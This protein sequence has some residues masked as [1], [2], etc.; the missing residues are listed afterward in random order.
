MMNSGVYGEKN[1]DFTGHGKRPPGERTGQRRQRF[2]R[3]TS[4]T[5]TGF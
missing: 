3:R 2:G 1:A 5:S 4:R